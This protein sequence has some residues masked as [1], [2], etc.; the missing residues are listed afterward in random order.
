MPHSVRYF[1]GYTKNRD[2]Y[3][4]FHKSQ[5][6]CVPKKGVSKVSPYFEV[7]ESIFGLGSTQFHGF[8]RVLPFYSDLVL[9]IAI[10]IVV[11]LKPQNPLNLGDRSI[12][13]VCG[14][15]SC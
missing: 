5:E 14:K 11:E 6:E 4:S 15:L 3:T 2:V 9:E 12:I 7:H 13:K 10:G 8:T 1:V